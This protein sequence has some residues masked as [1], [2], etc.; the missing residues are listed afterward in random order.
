M[1]ILLL[2]R[3]GTNIVQRFVRLPDFVCSQTLG[4]V[5]LGTMRRNPMLMVHVDDMIMYGPK[6]SFATHWAN[7]GKGDKPSDSAGRFH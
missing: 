5:A 4:R 1:V 3:S 7:L 6:A 2:A